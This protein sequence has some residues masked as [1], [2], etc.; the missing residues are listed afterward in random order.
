MP[1]PAGASVVV[2]LLGVVST[3]RDGVLVPL[4]GAR[5]RI[6]LAALASHPGRSRTA[7][8]LIDEVWGEQSPRSPMNA[9]HTQVSRLRAALPD[10]ALEIGPSGYRLAL[11]KAQVDLT[12]ARLLE[13]RAQQRQAEGDHQG[14]VDTVA[15]ARELWRGEPGSDLRDGPLARELIADAAARRTALAQVE[16]AARTALGDLTGA[17][18]TARTLADHSP[19]DENAHLELMR[20]LA[21][22]GR[23][24]EALDVFAALRSRLVDQL[25]T[26]PARALIDLNAAILRGEAGRSPEPAR[27]Q[28]A[29]GLRAAPNPLLGRSADI[30]AI[31]EV[32]NSARVTTVLGP[33]GTGKTRMAHELGFRA[34]QGIPVALVELASLR[35]G[36]D[37]IAAISGTLGVSEVDM[38]PGGLSRTRLHS[39]AS[40]CVTRWRLDRCC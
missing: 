32:M 21:G 23:D 16:V 5:A 28:P 14:A 25:G 18:A 39:G 3:R 30:A 6:L 33:G 9:L 34:A 1:T 31:E 26:D 11:G 36:E 40:A 10:G 4:P 15:E 37:V 13:Q 19:L 27:A 12:L 24:N 8:A 20:I 35:S 38:K 7:A 17:L 2:A 29:I 22:L